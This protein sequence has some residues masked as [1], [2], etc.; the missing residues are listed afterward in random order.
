[1]QI[2]PAHAFVTLIGTS[3][4]AHESLPLDSDNSNHQKKGLK[5]MKVLLSEFS[6]VVKRLKKSKLCAQVRYCLS[7]MRGSS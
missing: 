2:V 1:M 6:A 7:R 5:S 4:S 3:Q